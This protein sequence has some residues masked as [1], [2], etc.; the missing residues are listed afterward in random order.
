MLF[1]KNNTPLPPR[2]SYVPRWA[3]AP[4]DGAG[5]SPASQ[6]QAAGKSSAQPSVTHRAPKHHCHD[7]A[8][9]AGDRRDS[10][11]PPPAPQHLLTSGSDEGLR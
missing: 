7:G 8:V 5:R 3:V 11:E 4:R 6:V 10:Q 9:S 2:P 1:L